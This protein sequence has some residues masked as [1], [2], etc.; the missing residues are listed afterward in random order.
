MAPGD[1][2]A[3]RRRAER[4]EVAAKDLGARLDRVVRLGLLDRDESALGT[5]LPESRLVVVQ[6]VRA[7][8]RAAPGA[9]RA[10]SR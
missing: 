7:D 6:H 1:D 9:T 8:A 10:R 2:V 5:A 4:G 3:T